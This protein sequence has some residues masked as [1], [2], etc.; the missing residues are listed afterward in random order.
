MPRALTLAILFLL[1]SI[2]LACDSGSGGGADAATTTDAGGTDAATP[3]DAGAD[4]GS[5]ATTVKLGAGD[6]TVT[7]EKAALGFT[8]AGK[9]GTLLTFPADG[10]Q[11][12][13]VLALDDA[14]DYDPY[15]M[16]KGDP[17]WT[18]P[19]G[20]R[21]LNVKAVTLAQSDAT[22]AALDLVFEK[23]VKTSLTFTVSGPGSVKAALVPT[24]GDVAIA[25]IRLRPRADATEAFYGLGAF[26][27]DVNSRGKI[28][29]MQMETGDLESSDNEAH[30][31]IPFVIGTKGWGLFV[32][33]YHPGVFD[34]ASKE[35]DLVDFIA[36]TAA[37]TAKGLTFHLFAAARPLDVTKLYYDAT[38]YPVLPARWAL[39]PWHWRDENKDQAQ[40]EDDINKIRDLD[41]AYSG[42]WIDRPYATAVNTFDFSAQKF[43]DPQKMI[44]FAHAEGLRMGLWNSPYLDQSD[45]GAAT[46]LKYATDNDFY[47][48]QHG[49]LLNHWG[50]PI[51]FTKQAAFDWWQ[52]LIKKY[53]D[54][55]IEGFKMDYGED[56]AVGVAGA[57]NLWKFHDGTDERTMHRGYKLLYHKAY[58]DMLPK[59]G[60]WLLCRAGGWGDQVN[61]RVVWPGDL[62]ATFAKSGE[63]MADQQGA[64]YKSVGGLP[65][66]MIYGLTVGPS[67]FPFYAADT[68][69]YRHSPPDKELLTRWF[70]QT[71][72][73]TSMNIGDSSSI[74]IWEFG[75]GTDYD[76]EMLD[77]FKI[78]ARL[79]LRLNAYEWTYALNIKNDGRPITR[80]F[81][82]VYPE[83][84][85]HPSDVYLFGDH[86]FVA[87]VLTRNA[88]TRDVTS[89]S[90]QRTNSND[91][92]PSV[93]PLF[94]GKATTDFMNG[95]VA[96]TI[97]SAAEKIPRRRRRR[98]V[99]RGKQP[100]L[101]K[102]GKRIGR[103]PKAV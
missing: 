89:S 100:R 25:Y 26:L 46:L 47:P 61:V 23:D 45:Q 92:Y 10:I 78:Y 17:G 80:A 30:Y 49:L 31:P 95:P 22:S 73:S 71:A 63:E 75:Q 37:D 59:E 33:L 67:G 18:P 62:D 42:L 69:G 21:W 2:P 55:G 88:R 20:L 44:D 98:R 86:L 3:A 93:S 66:A 12:G 52:S 48:L 40:V 85:L 81:G 99:A 101:S 24:P 29:S 1:A 13:A 76:Q 87:P 60:G 68:G 16:A 83:T 90:A 9:G 35:A 28:R 70:E 32:E 96:Q 5:P 53:T 14:V 39:G 6:F 97:K 38:A 54:M 94:R 11:L 34:V 43:T 74:A 102:N 91:S 15:P 57:R 84:G 103:P 64:M 65:A 72:L 51:D 77:W 41:L 27:D 58:G 8:L 7:I 19:K 82:L 4:G 50:I 79:H 36:A 56:V